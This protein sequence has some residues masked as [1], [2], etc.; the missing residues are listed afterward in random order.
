MEHA[1][2]RRRRSRRTPA[3]PRNATCCGGASPARIAT[4]LRASRS[5]T[6]I[7]RLSPDVTQTW[8]PSGAQ[9]TSWARNGVGN[10]RTSRGRR[11]S[12]EVEQGEAVGLRPECG[13]QQLASGAGCD[14]PG[15]PWHRGPPQDRSSQDVDGDDLAASRVRDVGDRSPRGIR[16]GRVANRVHGGVPRLAEATDDACTRSVGRVEDRKPPGRR[17]RDNGPRGEGALDAPRAGTVRIRPA[18]APVP[19]SSAT[20]CDSRSAVTSAMAVP[21]DACARRYARE[22]QRERK[23]RYGAR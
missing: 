21:P 2:C 8:A 12:L 14:M 5:Y 17:V 13:P 3:G 10:V 22:S 6:A 18:T 16:V 15:R 11:G 23:A 7:R 20:T 4:G 19:R 9:T 1:P